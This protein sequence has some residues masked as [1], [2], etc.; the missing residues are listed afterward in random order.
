MRDLL[1]FCD[2]EQPWLRAAIESLVRHVA[3]GLGWR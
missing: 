1:K 2:A 3:P